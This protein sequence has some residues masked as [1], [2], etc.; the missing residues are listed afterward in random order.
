MEAQSNDDPTSA[1]EIAQ[2]LVDARVN[3]LVLGFP[4]CGTTAFADWLDLSDRIEVSNPKETFQ[5]CPEFSENSNRAAS[6]T[7]ETMFDTSA[8]IRVEATTLNVYSE[9]LRQAAKDITDVKVI[10]L[11]REPLQSVVSWHNQMLQANL[12]FSDDFTSAWQHGL[13][14]NDQMGTGFLR[15]YHQICS[16]GSWIEKWVDAV[17]H[18]RLLLVEN[19][20]LRSKETGE[21]RSL[22]SRFFDTQVE[23]PNLVPERNVYSSIRFPLLYRLLRSKNVKTFFRKLEQS[24]QAFGSIRRFVRDRIMLRRKKKDMP[25]LDG[26][27]LTAYFNSESE[28]ADHLFKQNRSFWLNHQ[29][30]VDAS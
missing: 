13:G 5:L 6:L 19:S 29:E 17:G 2:K 18:Q 21:L 14:L 28:T 30:L 20:E 12:A 11:T 16:F 3:Y 15:Q 22:L 26:A 7:L 4:K 24:F 25:N 9:Q 27:D 10:I 23:L 8:P 1:D